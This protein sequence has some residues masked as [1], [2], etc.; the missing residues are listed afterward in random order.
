MNAPCAVV[1]LFDAVGKPLSYAI[2]PEALIEIS[3]GAL[4]RI[5]LNN[6]FTTG[7][8]VEI[9]EPT[10]DGKLKPIKEIIYHLPPDLMA[11]AHWLRRYY[12]ADLSSA[13]GVIVPREMRKRRK[14]PPVFAKAV[15]VR[16]LQRIDALAESLVSRLLSGRFHRVLL[17]EWN[18]YRRAEIY[19]ALVATAL[20]SGGN[21]L[22]LVPEISKAERLAKLMEHR[23]PHLLWHGRLS[24]GAR[25]TVWNTLVENRG[26]FAVIGTPAAV[27]LPIV[28]PRLIIVDGEE[29]DSYKCEKMPRFHR[30]DCAVYRASLNQALCVLGSGAPSLESVHACRRGKFQRVPSDDPAPGAVGDIR[31]VDTKNSARNRSLITTILEAELGRCAQSGRQGILILN[32]LG[33][34]KC[35]FCHR[36]NLEILCTKCGT[37]MALRRGM[38]Q[39]FCP[40]CSH[41]ER[42]T[43]RCPNCHS[44]SLRA[45]GAGIERMEEILG[46]IF[47]KARILRC[48]HSA[49]ASP[50]K[51]MAF[52]NTVESGKIDIVIGTHA[53]IDFIRAPRVGLVAVLNA[54]QES[55]RLDFRA[56]ER[57]FQTLSRICHI[58]ASSPR[59]SGPIPLILQTRDPKNIILQAVIG[60][61]SSSFYAAELADRKLLGYPP[62]RHLIQQ[63][64]LGKSD[65]AVKRFAEKWATLFGAKMKTD[66]SFQLKGP[67][68]LESHRGNERHCLWYLTTNPISLTEKLCETREAMPRSQE[69]DYSWDVDAQD[70]L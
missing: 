10:F 20:S 64:F 11:L 5:P 19:A 42:H 60:G 28:A 31:I 13:L 7:V 61:N 56:G 54:D 53:A 51:I 70:L 14:N 62:H 24:L 17:E 37:P 21:V 15:P 27:F 68:K 23:I 26:A 30:R 38:G 35:I 32:R 49:L 47:P 4:V 50:K 41:V 46:Q 67:R 29:D 12:G 8:V 3:E 6:R 66:K 44:S 16:N 1:E 65:E 57:A 69:V 9:G 48:D 36:C 63:V 59:Q 18:F 34:E 58:C 33:Y 43:T 52:Q 40:A 39:R 55:R 22:M 2:P 25:A 45:R